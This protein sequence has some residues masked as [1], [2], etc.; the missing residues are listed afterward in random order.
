VVVRPAIK[1]PAVRIALHEEHAK[2]AQAAK[3]APAAKK[4]EPAKESE[5]EKK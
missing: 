3:K 2:Q 4:P 1:N 5:A